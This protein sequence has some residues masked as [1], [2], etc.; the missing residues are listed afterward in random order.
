MGETTTTDDRRRALRRRTLKGAKA[1]YGD[2]RYSYDCTVRNMSEDGALVRSDHTTEIPDDF[3]LF[4]PGDQ[5]V[6]RAEVV[7]RTARD[8][9]VRFLGEPVNVHTSGDPKLARFRF[10]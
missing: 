4:D 2:F 9:G 7:W 10:M 5:S 6:Q 3:Y 8:L 1:V